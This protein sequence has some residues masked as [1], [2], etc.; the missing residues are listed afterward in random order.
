MPKTFQWGILG[1][2]RIAH[3]F[4][5]DLRIV[6]DARLVA[7]ASRSDA[8]AHDFAR[9]YGA[10]YSA[11]SYLGLFDGPHL[12]A[13][14]IATPHSSHCELTL[15]CLRHG[16]PVLCEKPLGMNLAEVEVMVRQARERKVFLMEALWTRFLPT[17]LKILEL[18]EGGAIG[19]VLSI[20]ADFGF[21]LADEPPAR[22]VDPALGGGALLD[23]GIYPVFL[24][25]QLLGEPVAVTAMSQLG[26]TGVDLD[27]GAI[28]RAADGTLAHLHATLLTRTKTEAFIYGDRGLIHWHTRW[29]EPSQFTLLRP[30]ERPETFTFDFPSGGYHYEAKAVQE[31]LAQGYLESPA[32]SLDHSLGLHRTLTRIRE[33]AGIR[34]PGE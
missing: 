3:K 20:K 7:V 22:L 15:L 31:Y 12:D 10:E 26:T 27:T 19:K 28:L 14:Y 13:V 25:Y 5:Q 8:R 17:T 30:G 11:G 33:A 16:V 34:Y 9:E 21:R 2:G 18:V 4:A 24:A 32:W 23:I 1:L 29:H 6:P